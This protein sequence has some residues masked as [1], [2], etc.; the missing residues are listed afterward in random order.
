MTE[1]VKVTP[2]CPYGHGDLVHD[3][4]LYALRGVK[5][6]ID[7]PKEPSVEMKERAYIANLYRCPA[8][9]YLEMFTAD[10]ADPVGECLSGAP[11]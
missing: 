6:V 3:A 2:R 5:L 8:C 11:S 7:P 1:T 10:P 9:G 4:G